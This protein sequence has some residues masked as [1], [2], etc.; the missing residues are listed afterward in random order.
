MICVIFAAHNTQQQLRI[1]DYC[2]YSDLSLA[3]LKYLSDL[4]LIGNWNCSL[5]VSV[6]GLVP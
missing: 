4:F 2:A 3:G 5:C 1:Y 6:P